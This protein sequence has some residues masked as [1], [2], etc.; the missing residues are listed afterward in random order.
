[1]ATSQPGPQNVTLRYKTAKVF[2]QADTRGAVV[3]ELGPGD[4]FTVLSTEGEYYRVQLPDGTFGFIWAH[5]VD[6][7]HLPLTTN[8]QA[9]ADERAAE[10]ARPPGGWRGVANRLRGK[11]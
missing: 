7:E 2:A 3:T 9:H 4:P 10:A 8:E 6:G 5:N 11:R 1:M